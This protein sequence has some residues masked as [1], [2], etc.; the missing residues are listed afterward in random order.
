MLRTMGSLALI[1]LCV[2]ALGGQAAAAPKLTGSLVEKDD[3]PRLRAT[4]NGNPVI[5]ADRGPLYG[6]SDCDV[7]VKLDPLPEGLALV[8]TVSNNTDAPADLPEFY[9]P[10]IALPV[11]D[12][13]YLRTWKTVQLHRFNAEAGRIGI[14]PARCYPSGGCYSPVSGLMTPEAMLGAQ[15]IYDLFDLKVDMWC[16]YKYDKRTKQFTLVFQPRGPRV[17][18][19][20]GWARFARGTLAPGK[21]ATFTLALAAAPA[22]EW[23]KAFRP[24]RDHFRKTYGEVR[25]KDVRRDP[26]YALSLSSGRVRGPYGKITDENPRGYNG[27]TRMDKFGWPVYREVV[28]DRV[29]RRGFKRVMTWQVSGWYREHVRTNMVWEI[30]SAWPEK[31]NETVDVFKEIIDGGLAVGLWCGRAFTISEGFDSGKRHAWDPDN[32]ADNAAAFK[33]FD[34][35]YELGVRMIGCDATPV[36]IHADHWHPSN[37]VLFERIMPMLYERY[38]EMYWV[39]EVAPADYMH[40]WGGAFIWDAQVTGPNVFAQ[41][42]APGSIAHSVMKRG[43]LGKKELG[44]NWQERFDQLIEWGYVPMV[45]C[46]QGGKPVLIKKDEPAEDEPKTEYKEPGQE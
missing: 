12:L 8:Y 42:I 36:G 39:I 35:A 18:G 23:V 40:L 46:D 32:P 27:D 26:I 31:M 16:N 10:G 28:R 21:T 6:D 29:E 5:H 34:R 33:E 15:M 4:L 45:F 22:D 37:I 44:L 43:R 2:F 9:V 25:Y 14:H 7:R 1:S 17:K 24:Y 30:T 13:R 41:Y 19:A 20:K 11:D 3:T 38:P